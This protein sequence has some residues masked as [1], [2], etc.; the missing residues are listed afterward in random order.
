M[1]V[2]FVKLLNLSITAGWLILV[3]LVVRV[4]FRR[5]PKWVNCLMWG[6][7]A[8]RLVLPFS[9]E[10]VFSLQPSAE[11]I[12]MS[13]QIEGETYPYMPSVNS[14]LPVI[15]NAINPVLQE[16]FAY[17]ETD[18]VAPLQ[19]VTEIAGWIWLVGLVGFL[20]FAGIS[21]IR[22]KCMV[23]E[24]VPYKKGRVYV[25][26]A[27]KSPFILGLIRPGIY[28][29]ATLK[30]E[31]AEYILAHERAHLKRGDHLWKP[32]GYLLLSVYWFNPLCIV[33][34]FFLC[35]DIELACDEKVIRN[36]DLVEKKE[37]SKVL[38]ACATQRRFVMVCPL[39]FGEVGVKER[40]KS[41]LKH[42]KAALWLTVIAILV[43]TVVAVCFL[44]NPKEVDTSEETSG[45]AEQSLEN[46]GNTTDET[47]SQVLEKVQ[48]IYQPIAEA[49]EEFWRIRNQIHT[50]DKEIHV[51]NTGIYFEVREDKYTSVADIQTSLNRLFTQNYQ[52]Q[53]LNWVLGGVY[54]F[55]REI[56]GKLC[57]LMADEVSHALG[58]EIYQIEECTEDTIILYSIAGEGID[59]VV[60]RKGE[61][62]WQIDD[63][64][65]FVIS[66]SA[67]EATESVHTLIGL[68]M[69]MTT[70][71][72]WEGVADITNLSGR[73]LETD[74]TC[75][76]QMK[77]NET[78]YP[79][80]AGSSVWKDG[81][82]EL[83][84]GLTTHVTVNWS[85]TYGKLHPG[86]YRILK[87]VTDPGTGEVFDLMSEFKIL[88]SAINENEQAL[89]EAW[90]ANREYPVKTWAQCQE[91]GGD[92]EW[93]RIVS[94]PPED[95]LNDLSTEELVHLV[96]HYPLLPYMPSFTDVDSQIFCATL[97]G[98]CTIFA[99]LL[100]KEERNRL[101]LNEYASNVLDAEAY[102]SGEY[103]LGNESV[104]VE[105]LTEYYVWTYSKEFTQEERQ[106]YLD[107]VA[108]KDETEYTLIK[109]GRVKF[110]LSFDPDGSAYRAGYDGR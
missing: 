90:Y 55:F 11:P 14:R 59:K 100:T 65:E 8:L 28:L 46:Q 10:S 82:H 33:A 73:E 39:A 25:C 9:L 99:R 88:P 85:E 74:F 57:V 103:I 15:D 80:L 96:M 31:D 58:K 102:N 69:E 105:I 83:K 48:A 106:Y 30:E 101:I 19:V 52:E 75:E 1:G 45:K 70:Y 12:Q 76:L 42:K 94:N 20:L 29:P 66:L 17:E 60:L 21:T 43:C 16:T 38:L 107:I 34:Y 56:D 51:G 95:L 13:T 92:L 24:A 63:M 108:R 23:R 68:S 104:W 41:V 18:S 47:D 71:A 36:M 61:S 97:E 91:L 110:G 87:K 98:Y 37:Y 49:Y 84:D 2:F 86:N 93:W 22:L 44:T 89:I 64:D 53:E 67:G 26:D 6:A 72:S 40:V 4:L 77:I 62:G 5:M 7:V 109:E 54:P 35:K 50:D 27:V 81:S 32:V 78:W 3:V 79:L